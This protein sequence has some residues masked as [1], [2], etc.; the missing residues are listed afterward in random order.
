[1]APDLFGS[2]G[3]PVLY[4]GMLLY[5]D[6]Q[7]SVTAD[8]VLRLSLGNEIDDFSPKRAYLWDRTSNSTMQREANLHLSTLMQRELDGNIDSYKSDQTWCAILKL[9]TV[10]SSHGSDKLPP[11]EWLK[12]VQQMMEGS[13]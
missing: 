2:K 9:V 7:P 6:G 10:N 13:S 4:V 1:M 8:V 11:C 5:G 12:D 3:A